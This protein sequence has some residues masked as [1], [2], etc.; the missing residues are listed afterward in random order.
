MVVIWEP[1]LTAIEQ[2]ILYRIPDLG[3][4]V[5][6]GDDVAYTPVVVF[7]AEA[8]A[9]GAVGWAVGKGLD[10]ALEKAEEW[11]NDDD[12]ADDDAA[13]DDDDDDGESREHFR[14]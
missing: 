8:A 3:S 4:S 9:A 6:I 1:A 14:E 2:D 5:K 10:Y 13:D 12:D 7:I 11:A